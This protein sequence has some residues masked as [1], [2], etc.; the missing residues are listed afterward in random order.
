MQRSLEANDN[1]IGVSVLFTVSKM[2]AGPIISQQEYE[3][4]ENE[5]ATTVLPHLFDVGTELLLEAIPNVLSGEI[6]M[7]SSKVV[8]EQ[9]EEKVMDAS[10]IRA[11]EA[12]LMLWKES[13]RTVHNR[14]RGF[15][16]WPG[17]FL[18]VQVGVDSEPQKYKIV[19]TRVLDDE[20]VDPTDEIRLGPTKKSG[21]R[22]VCYD[23]SVLEVL[24]LQ[25]ATKK[26]MD[27][28]SFV[29]G[30]QGRDAKW[31]EISEEEET[32]KE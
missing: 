15:S 20:K 10:M 28:K 11:E 6:T 8:W 18:Y 30:L 24:M 5:Q 29:N 25:P 23:G 19:T 7:D 4:N 2:D 12:E 22:F 9:S 27:A 14:V 1:P 16:M 32:A 17:T 21:L 31:V 26:V 13:A 3:V